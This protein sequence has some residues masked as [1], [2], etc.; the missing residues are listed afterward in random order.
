MKL[1]L[2]PI[3]AAYAGA[4]TINFDL[5]PS[6]TI[7][8]GVPNSAA[9]VLTNQLNPLGVL[10]GLQGVS[11]GVAVVSVATLND[12]S[13]PNSIVGLDSNGE[14]VPTA[15]GDIYF[16]F[17]L[18]GTNTPGETDFVSFFV[19]DD[20]CDIDSVD[21][22]A[23]SIGGSLL[24]SQSLQGTSWQFF[25]LALPGIHRIEV[26]NTSPHTSGYALDD[27]TFNTPTSAVPEPASIAM[28]LI[29]VVLLLHRKKR[30]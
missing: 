4:A 21:I 27:L 30:R 6:S 12:I 23:Y 5:L 2:I 7:P 15:A 9:S 14:I 13:G 3:L 8:S 1:L 11:S 29:G 18:P 24:H 10:F 22:R 25:S 17:V 20:C 19:G 28:T 26:E 16:Q